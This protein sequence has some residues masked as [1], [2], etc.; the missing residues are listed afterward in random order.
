MIVRAGY[1][2]N[3]AKEH[4]GFNWHIYRHLYNVPIRNYDKSQKFTL[5]SVEPKAV[6]QADL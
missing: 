2:L 3:N 1:V 6:W 5:C 4:H